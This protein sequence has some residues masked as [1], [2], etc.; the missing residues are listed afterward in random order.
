M[1]DVSI[2]L[3]ELVDFEEAHFASDI[4]RWELSGEKFVPLPR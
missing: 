1:L 2:E 3:D 4:V